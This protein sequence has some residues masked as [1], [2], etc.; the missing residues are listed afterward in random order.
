MNSTP[1]MSK[2]KEIPTLSTYA[3]KSIRR[4]LQGLGC[5][6]VPIKHVQDDN[7]TAWIHSEISHEEQSQKSA[8]ITAWR[9]RLQS[10]DHNTWQWLRRYKASSML[11]Y[12]TTTDGNITA[13]D[14]LINQIHTYWENI[15]PSNQQD[16]HL[17]H[18]LANT[19]PWPEVP[20]PTYLQ[21]RQTTYAKT[22]VACIA[23]LV[24]RTHG[25][26]K[27]SHSHHSKHWN[28]RLK[29]STPLKTVL[30]GQPH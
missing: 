1:I 3:W 30:H 11:T 16:T 29:F 15:W 9:Q 27:K 28:S 19:A 12:T 23:E 24:D 8:R 26:P 25:Q 7:I 17:L 21:S 13:G 14:D 5:P 10:S 2:S 18:Q 4:N 6:Q 22:H 20:A